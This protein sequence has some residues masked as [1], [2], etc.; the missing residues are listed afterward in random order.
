MVVFHAAA[1]FPVVI[2]TLTDT[3]QGE[4]TLFRDLGPLRPVLHITYKIVPRF[5]GYPR[6]A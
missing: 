6:L 3:D 1:F 5:S 4:E 2:L